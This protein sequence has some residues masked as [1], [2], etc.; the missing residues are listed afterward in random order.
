MTKM[1]TSSQVTGRLRSGGK[2]TTSRR[3]VKD[4]R[5]KLTSSLVENFGI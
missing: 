4:L 1:F 2:L 3:E 5:P